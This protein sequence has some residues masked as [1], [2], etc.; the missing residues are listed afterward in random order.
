MTSEFKIFMSEV[1]ITLAADNLKKS[2]FITYK[3]I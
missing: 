1:K 2:K 3:L